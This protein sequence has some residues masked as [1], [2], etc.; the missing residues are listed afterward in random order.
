[1]NSGNEIVFLNGSFLRREE[2]AVPALD[3]GFMFADGVYE[4]LRSYRGS[5][6]EQAAHIERLRRSLR[7]IRIGQGA[8]DGIEEIIPGL[9]ER[10]GLAESEA[11][12][13]IQ[14]T[15]GAAPRTHQFPVP[16]TTPTVYAHAV[17]FD[18]PFEQRDRGIPVILVPDTRWKRCDIKSIALLPNILARQMAEDAGA[19]ESIFIRDGMVTEGSSSTFCA[20]FSGTVVTH[21]ESNVVL[22]GITKR[23]VF[24]LC[25][26]TGI[27][28]AERPFREDELTRAAEMMLLS[29]TREVMP[30]ISVDGMEV[31]DGTPGQ[32][33]RKIQA[34]FSEVIRSV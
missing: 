34:A 4:V 31:G 5:L 32:L 2:A 33:T 15:R 12:V 30:I 29:T 19:G 28:V 1:M 24:D 11:L 20:V 18:P 9:L 27:P 6:F 14:I 16:E 21:P 3:R 22:S 8:A 7:E 26:R 17:P 13:Y 23:V 10:N 25:T